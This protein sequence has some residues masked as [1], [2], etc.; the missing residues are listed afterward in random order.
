[1]HLELDL[2]TPVCGLEFFWQKGHGTGQNKSIHVRSSQNSLQDWSEGLSVEG[3]AAVFGPGGQCISWFKGCVNDFQ[4]KSG[5]RWQVGVDDFLCKNGAPVTGITLSTRVGRLSET[6]SD[7]GFQWLSY[8]VGKMVRERQGAWVGPNNI[9][10][11]STRSGIHIMRKWYMEIKGHVRPLSL[12][13]GE[14]EGIHARMHW[15][16]LGWTLCHVCFFVSD[17]GTFMPNTNC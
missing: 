2:R 7:I 13:V 9:E 11:S 3:K 16:I 5:E 17:I 8:H 15:F 14:S 10:T 1:M 12:V 6:H 4:W